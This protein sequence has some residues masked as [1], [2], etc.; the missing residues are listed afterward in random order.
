MKT[1]EIKLYKFEELSEAVQQKVLEKLWDINVDYEWWDFIYDDADNVNL[2]ISGF[3]I[4]RGSYCE[5]EFTQISI[6]TAKAILKN[7]G[8]TCETYV[9]AKNFLSEHNRLQN[10]YNKYSDLYENMNPETDEEE[11]QEQEYYDLMKS[12]EDDIEEL[13]KEFLNDL[14]NEYLSNLRK[15]YDYLTSEEAIK[16][17]IEAN[18]YDFTE[19][20]KIY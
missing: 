8:E 3:D 4:G 2:K 19:N 12:F 17:A 7:H 18:D 20:G 11:Q 14:S 9:L 1:V 16:E 6:D 15:S 13:E 5:I 10:E